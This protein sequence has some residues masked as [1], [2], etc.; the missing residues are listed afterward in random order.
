MA[1]F[2][3]IV[4][5]TNQLIVGTD[6]GIALLTLPS[7]KEEKPTFKFVVDPEADKRDNR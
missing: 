7:K 4:G 1:C 5:T 3:P 6:H 2:A